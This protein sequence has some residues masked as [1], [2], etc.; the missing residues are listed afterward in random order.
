MAWF[1][2]SKLGYPKPAPT[3][4]A[5]DCAREALVHQG[6]TAPSAAVANLLV[7]LLWLSVNV[8]TS[9]F[10]YPGTFTTKAFAQPA[11]IVTTAAEAPRADLASDAQQ[12][13]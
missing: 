5:K 6:I 2:P 12:K 1:I 8:L 11:L 9:Q 7:L 3:A 10:P 4:L 13:W